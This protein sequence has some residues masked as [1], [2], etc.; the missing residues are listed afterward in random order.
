M[1]TKLLPIVL[2][3]CLFAVTTM[4][5][6]ADCCETNQPAACCAAALAPVPI[7]DKSLYQLESTWTTD[8]Q[9]KI[10]L[11]ELAGRP[12]VVVMFFASCQYACPILV[13]DLKRLEAALPS[14]SRD[15]VGFTLVTFDTERDTP[16]AL[17]DYRAIRSL[18]DSTWTLLHG[19]S[20][21]VLELAALL[22]VKYKKDAS[23]QFAH[24]NIITILNAQGEIVQ[25]LVGLNQDITDCVRNI[26]QLTA[27]PLP[28][29]AQAGQPD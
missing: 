20:D 23:G 27:E 5:H 18:P 25:Q 9:T 17:A 19:E 24:S 4:L 1:K 21:D 26:R 16:A 15:K 14:E 12:Q 22:G 13:N 29:S 8:K 11:S 3:G 28:V 7:T 2:I 10:E 6:G